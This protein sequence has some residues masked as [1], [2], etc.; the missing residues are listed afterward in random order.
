MADEGKKPTRAELAE[1]VRELRE[2]MAAI[3][4]ERNAHLCY[5]LTC[6]AH[7][8]CNR[9]H[10]NCWTWHSDV[11]TVPGCAPAYP[12]V[13]YWTNVNGGSATLTG[14]SPDGSMVTIT[15][16]TSVAAGV[17]TVMTLG[18]LS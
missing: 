7:A 1:A 10:C 2:E 4:A 14:N 13:T 12:T 11:Y 8:H 5:G 18:A 9:G 6:A 3:R 16:K 15:G 17:P